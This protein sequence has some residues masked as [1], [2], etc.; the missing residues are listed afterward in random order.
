MVSTATAESTE[1]HKRS[2]SVSKQQRSTNQPVSVKKRILQPTR[3]GNRV[4]R[5]DK[6]TNHR[7]VRLTRAE[8]RVSRSD[9]AHKQQ[10]FRQERDR[11]RHEQ[12]HD[13]A[14][15][16]NRNHGFLTLF[17][18]HPY[19]Y[20]YH[21][22]RYIPL[23]YHGLNYFYNNGAYYR[24]TG[25][26]FALVN[27]NIGIYLY[28]L[29]FGYRTLMIGGYPYYY[30][31]RHFYIRDYVRRVY[32]Q[33]D[34]PY[35]DAGWDD[36]ENDSSDYQELIVY[37]KQGQ[38]EDQMKQDVYECYLW[39]VDE[40]GFDPSLG[41]AGNIQDYQRAKSACLEGRGYVVN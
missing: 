41:N 22:K 39:A 26:S 38:S 19:T 14:Y 18:Y 29:P 25:F 5:A 37:P 24:Y 16:K 33:V 9:T 28:S 27:H 7:D 20:V 36:A 13:Y 30:A 40:T 34:D 3:N 8:K 23:T 1:R 17:N 35:Q 31:N 15:N 12:H 2:S 10:T 11:D 6:S 32:V 4:V 21:R